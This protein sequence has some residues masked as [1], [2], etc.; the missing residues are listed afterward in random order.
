MVAVLSLISLPFRRAALQTWKQRNG[1]KA[2]YSKLMKIFER[3]GYRNHADK[4]RK[5]AEAS[6]SETDDS[7]G[8]GEEQSQIEQPQTYP[9]YEQQSLSQLPPATATT[10]DTETYYVIEN[11]E[12][13]PEGK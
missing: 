2:T 11:E 3:A 4:L 5:I 6:D 7:S 13:L 10:T 1:S 12:N 9:P 8:S